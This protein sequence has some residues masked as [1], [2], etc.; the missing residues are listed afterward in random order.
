[1]K[2]EGAASDGAQLV[3][4]AFHEAVGEA[5]TDIAP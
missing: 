1:M 5:I 4:D 2:A 3:V